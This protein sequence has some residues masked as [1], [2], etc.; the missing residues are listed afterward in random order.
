MIKPSISLALKAQLQSQDAALTPARV[1]HLTEAKIPSSLANEVQI[2][3]TY[4]KASHLGMDVGSNKSL[5]GKG[6]AG[7]LNGKGLR[8]KAGAKNVIIQNIHITNLNPQ[9][10]WGGDGIS[11]SGNDGVWIDHVKVRYHDVNTEVGR[12]E[13]DHSRS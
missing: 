2:T 7:V 1:L 9:Y 6:S 4:D 8:F 5:V 13:A 3:V 12:G 11:L 10:V